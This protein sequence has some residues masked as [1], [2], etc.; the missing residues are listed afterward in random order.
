V[1]K[2]NLL[3]LLDW[4]AR[5]LRRHPIEAILLASAM[6]LLVAFTGIGVLLPRALS[7]TASHILAEGPSIVVRRVGPAGWQPL[8]IKE[9]LE[10]ARRIPGAL[11][12]RT[13]IW[14]LAATVDGAVT[15]VGLE[16]PLPMNDGT[17]WRPVPGQAAT[18]RGVLPV[19]KQPL[20]LSGVSILSLSVVG[21]FSSRGDLAGFDIV[22]VHPRDARTL[23]GLQPGEATDL[24][25]DVFHAAEAQAMLPELATAFPWPVTVTCRSE[26][27]GRFA[28]SAALH[29]GLA[30]LALVPAFLALA[31]LI[32]LE[33]R[34]NLSRHHEAGLLKALGWS[35]GEVM[36]LSLLRAVLLGLPAVVCGMAAAYSLLFI[37]R[38]AGVAGRFFGWQ[39]KAPSLFLDP[40]GALPLLFA[41]A[42]LVLAPFLAAVL[43]PALKAASVD[44]QDMLEGKRR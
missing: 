23:L 1:K 6:T 37:P 10:A 39:G 36:R 14:G 2:G 44:P 11:A 26:E 24:A 27:S 43:F 42:G 31:L 12:I 30:V 8:P 17:E 41:V 7:D 9:A 40:T 25:M 13:R 19:G 35:A 33:V 5:D 4:A 18:G 15:V 20:L 32:A 3:P 22:A 38:F 28:V 29:G 16:N 21:S 34:R